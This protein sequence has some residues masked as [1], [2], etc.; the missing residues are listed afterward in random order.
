[1]PGVKSGSVS[2]GF[3]GGRGPWKQK[4]PF[5]VPAEVGVHLA[6][7]MEVGRLVTTYPQHPWCPGSPPSRIS[8]SLGLC[9]VGPKNRMLLDPG[10]REGRRPG[11]PQ[12]PMPPA[13]FTHPSASIPTSCSLPSLPLLLGIQMVSTA[14]PPPPE[15]GAGQG[16]D[17]ATPIALFAPKPPCF[18]RPGVCPRLLSAPPL[19]RLA[20]P[21]VHPAASSLVSD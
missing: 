14:A 18:L 2:S 13:A 15:W 1:M 12:A 9:T 19:G 21:L 8:Q 5:Q 20:R 16:G 7:N 11:P 6:S 3:L 10:G 17:R 4:Q